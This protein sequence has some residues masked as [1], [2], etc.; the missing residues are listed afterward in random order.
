MEQVRIIEW[1]N[2]IENQVKELSVEVIELRRVKSRLNTLFETERKA[3][4]QKEER[5]A[6]LELK[7][8]EYR[9]KEASECQPFAKLNLIADQ[10][11]SQL[12]QHQKTHI[13]QLESSY[14]QKCQDIDQ[15]NNT[16]RQFQEMNRM[17]QEKISQL[18]DNDLPS[19]ESIAMLIQENLAYQSMG[20]EFEEMK[21]AQ[22]QLLNQSNQLHHQNQE[23]SQTII[24]LEQTNQELQTCNNQLNQKN[25][26]LS[27]QYESAATLASATPRVPQQQYQ[28]LMTQ[29]ADLQ[30]Q[31]QA[32]QKQLQDV[33]GNLC[34]SQQQQQSLQA[35][36]QSQEQE[37]RSVIDSLRNHVQAIMTEKEALDGQYQTLQKHFH[38]QRLILEQ[39]SQQQQ[40]QQLP[41]KASQSNRTEPPTTPISSSIESFL[42]SDLETDISII[43]RHPDGISSLLNDS[44][45]LVQALEASE[46]KCQQL[47]S[48]LQMHREIIDEL[49]KSGGKQGI[50]DIDETKL[51]Q[52]IDEKSRSLRMGSRLLILQKQNL[53]LHQKVEEL[54][55]SQKNLQIQLKSNKGRGSFEQENSVQQSKSKKIIK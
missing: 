54:E 26:Q 24:K 36:L 30:Q 27:E 34:A 49:E 25:I 7:V 22:A 31:H 4:I 5:V 10:Q 37:S 32:I 8:R 13:Q 6:E 50:F 47:S 52:Q 51:T 16:L 23:L 33:T 55:Q 46:M 21:G 53:A 42:D 38:Q 1:V 48:D 44:D 14:R 40:Q 2:K 43:E 3:R 9:Q 35:H 28:E 45:T 17:Q 11:Q 41:M 18:Q 20:R 39:L 15:L 12:V 29:H 19:E